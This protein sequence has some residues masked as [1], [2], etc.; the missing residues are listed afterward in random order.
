MP[1]KKKKKKEL[2]IAI[3]LVSRRPTHDPK[4]KKV[5]GSG[6]ARLGKHGM[7][8]FWQS[9]DS[10]DYLERFLVEHN[11]C[12]SIA[13]HSHSLRQRFYGQ[14]DLHQSA[15][16]CAQP[17]AAQDNPQNLSTARTTVFTRLFFPHPHT[18]KER[19]KERKKKKKRLD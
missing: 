14:I 10:G 13:S 3:S 11:W 18:E 1:K 6:A 4:K 8:L 7:A 16:L 12:R 9:T 2:M 5:V 17:E 19:K 15:G